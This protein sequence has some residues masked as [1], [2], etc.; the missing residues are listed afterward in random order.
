MLKQSSF[1]KERQ[2]NPEFKS[3][4]P[5]FTRNEKQENVTYN[6]ENNYH[7]IETDSYMTGMMGLADKDFKTNTVGLPWWRTG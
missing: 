4:Q 2:E 5:K 3:T 1:F 6:Q 7:L